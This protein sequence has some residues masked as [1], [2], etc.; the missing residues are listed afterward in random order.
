MQLEEG[1]ESSLDGNAVAELLLAQVHTWGS[2]GGEDSREAWL[3]GEEHV[4]GLQDR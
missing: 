1:W 4:L 3:M 2:K